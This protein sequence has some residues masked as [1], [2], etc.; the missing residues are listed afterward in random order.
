MEK[1]RVQ[2]DL[3][4]QWFASHERV[5]IALSGGVDSCLVSYLARHF[6]GPDQ[7]VAVISHSASLK[8]S[9]LEDARAFCAEHDIEL[10]IVDAREI[11]DPNYASNPNNRCYFCKSALYT[12]LARL[13]KEKYPGYAV[14]N[15]NNFSDLGDYRPGLEAADEFRV[16]S[17]LAECR[18]SKQDI[19][20]LARHFGLSTWDKPASPC[21]SSRF[22]YGQPITVERLRQVEAGE[23]ILNQYGFDDVRLRHFGKDARIEVPRHE[24]ARLQGLF[25]EIRPRILA[26][27]FEECLIDEEGLISGKLNRALKDVR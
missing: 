11:D 18:L 13:V 25:P 16:L 17:P 12:T 10:E 7:A 9:D 24:V 2:L 6:L 5:L 8:S 26:L 23:V 1:I 3:L 22:P 21:L 15:G 19:R 4:Q 20:A 14:L 27:G